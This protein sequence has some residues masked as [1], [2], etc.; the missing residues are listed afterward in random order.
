[1][2]KVVNKEEFNKVINETDIVIVDF[3]ATWCGPCKML[4]PVLEEVAEAKKDEITI[5]KV[6]VDDE[7]ELANKYHISSIPTI[8]IFKKGQIVDSAIGYRSKKNILDMLEKVSQ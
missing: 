6:D 8:L 1:M 2:M 5:I 4:S 7:V 3:F